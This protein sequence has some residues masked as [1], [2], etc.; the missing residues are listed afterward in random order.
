MSNE[1]FTKSH[2]WARKDGS[3]AVV[4]ISEFAAQ[5]L[6]DVVFVDLPQVG[7]KVERGKAMGVVE[8]VKTVSDLVAPVSGTI[9]KR[10]GD[11][12]DPSLVNQDPLGKGWMVEIEMT[13]PAELEE[14]LD[15][16]AYDQHC[17][18]SHH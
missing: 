17:A 4:G 7:A 1:K 11:L 9:A 15:K 16:T 14:L 8:S 13:R 2:E 5:Q 18:E 10:N 3:K 12:E 6:G